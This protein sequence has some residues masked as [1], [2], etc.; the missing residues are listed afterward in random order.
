VKGHPI[1]A[2]PNTFRTSRRLIT[3]PRGS[4]HGIVEVQASILEGLGFRDV[5]VGSKGN[6][7]GAAL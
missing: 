6:I 7:C 5:R 3:A 4:E 2:P 1:A